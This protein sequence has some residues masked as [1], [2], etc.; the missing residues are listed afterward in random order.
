MGAV[1]DPDASNSSWAEMEPYVIGSYSLRHPLSVSMKARL[2]LQYL[3]TM[4]DYQEV[5]CHL[6]VCMCVFV[7]V[8]G[9]VCVCIHVCVYVCVHMC[10]CSWVC[11]YKRVGQCVGTLVASLQRKVRPSV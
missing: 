8:C 11:E 9:Y 10:V 2:V 5:D 6:F 7:Y 1:F 4:G 3:A